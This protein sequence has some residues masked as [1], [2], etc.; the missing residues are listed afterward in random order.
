MT[1]N[2]NYP[3]KKNGM[4]SP[5]LVVGTSAGGLNALS[6]LV[7]Q[8]DVEWGLSVLVVLHVSQQSGG[9]YIIHHLSSI[10]SYTCKLADDD[11]PL[12]KNHI[13]IARPNKHLL[14]SED[15]IMH[16]SGPE[17]NRWRPSIDVL[18]RSA[19]A[20]TGANAIG[21]ILS[22]LLN[23]GTAGM[24]ALKK[25]GGVCIVQDPEDAEYPDMPKSVLSVLKA[26]Y[27]V[28]IKDMG[29]VLNSV[30]HGPL[31]KK[32]KVPENIQIEARISKNIATGFSDLKR[33]AKQS[34]F[35]CPDCSGGLWEM[36]DKKMI[37]YRCHIGHSYTQDDLMV[38]QNE[39]TE[40]T[41]WVALRMMEE[42]KTLMVKLQE[43]NKS[44]GLLKTLDI[45]ENKIKELTGH[46]DQL[47][48]ILG[49]L[50]ID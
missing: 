35:N 14:I 28:P 13:Y 11:E 4:F 29:K 42:R 50:Q 45:Y 10:T 6:H 15:R 25:S 19:A 7:K 37:R 3:G 34:L 20:N 8:F 1:N 27:C 17:E 49:N 40:A 43:Q 26:D 39:K 21:I 46:I 31:R 33:I 44:R 41:L 2:K 16:G 18:F 36:K 38:K 24:L 32:I 48:K 47:K 5:V 23:D 30:I 12:K 22:G 9:D